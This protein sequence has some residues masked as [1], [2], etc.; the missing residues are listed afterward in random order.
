MNCCFH[1]F[2]VKPIVGNKAI[3]VIE[4][5]GFNVSGVPFP[6]LTAEQLNEF[7]QTDLEIH[8]TQVNTI[9]L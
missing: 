8:L 5:V 6:A 7:S 9:H 1:V 4:K 3:E 2:Q